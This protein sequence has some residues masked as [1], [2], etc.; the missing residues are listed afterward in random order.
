M[1]ISRTRRRLVVTVSL[2]AEVL[3]ALAGGWAYQRFTLNAAERNL[4][5]TWSQTRDG[6]ILQ[7][8]LVEFTLRDDRTV[9]LVNKDAKT[10]AVTLDLEEY[11]WWRISDGVLTLR[12]RRE[13][14]STPWY[15]WW[16]RPRS[17]DRSD[18]LRIAPD[19]PDRVR[20]TLV[21]SDQLNT[22]LPDPL[23]KGTW[24]RVGAK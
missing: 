10:G 21:R 2:L 6:A 22:P 20:D 11:D 4:V 5:G 18:E 23:P 15:A 16:D 3:A 24:T 17:V 9:R 13:V 14:A 19:G 12:Q 7:S 1:A 8:V